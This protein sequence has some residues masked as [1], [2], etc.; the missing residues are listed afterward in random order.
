MRISLVYSED[1][2]NS[3]QLEQSLTQHKI[4]VSYCSI[5]TIICFGNIE[6]NKE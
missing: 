5:V 6:L 4:N 1:Y 2:I 3:T